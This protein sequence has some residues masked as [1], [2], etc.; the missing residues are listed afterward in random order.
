MSSTLCPVTLSGSSI[1]CWR[2]DRECVARHA[3]REKAVVPGKSKAVWPRMCRS[4][5]CRFSAASAASLPGSHAPDPGPHSTGKCPPH[6][7]TCVVWPGKQAS[8]SY[9]R[10]PLRVAPGSTA[11]PVSRSGSSTC[12]IAAV[13]MHQ[14]FK[15]STARTTRPGPWCY[16][17]GYERNCETR[18]V[19]PPNGA[20][21][22]LP[23]P[24]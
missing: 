6:G 19:A 18:C 2:G 23:G 22:A 14:P 7:R 9:E 4:S 3:Q 11:P 16:P 20:G 12:G 15:P 1:V 10:A 17:G 13:R 8:N 5:T 24:L 21:S